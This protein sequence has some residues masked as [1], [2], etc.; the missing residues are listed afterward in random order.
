LPGRDSVVVV[1]HTPAVVAPDDDE[2]VWAA[3]EPTVDDMA[4][5]G[6]AS[7]W[8]KGKGAARVRVDRPPNRIPVT[9]NN[10]HDVSA[11]QGLCL[12]ASR[13]DNK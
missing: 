9:P 2:D 5:V 6:R 12:R 13:S 10:A 1:V 11:G 4:Q 8:R 7:G 3:D